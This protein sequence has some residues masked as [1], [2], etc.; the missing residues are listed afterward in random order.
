MTTP[1]P[2]QDED[3][4]NFHAPATW[5]S[6]PAGAG[7][8]PAWRSTSGWPRARLRA[9]S[10]ISWRTWAAWRTT[11]WPR[12]CRWCGPTAGSRSGTAACWRRCPTRPTP[13]RLFAWEPLPLAAFNKMN[14]RTPLGRVAATL[15]EELGWPPERG[16]AYARR[17]VPAPGAAPRLRLSDRER[18][19]SVAGFRPRR[20]R[21]A[22][23][24][25]RRDDPDG[26]LFYRAGLPGRGIA[27][28]GG[29]A[30]RAACGAARLGRRPARAGGWPCGRPAPVCRG[31]SAGVGAGSVGD[32]A[33][34]GGERSPARAGG[35]GARPE[36]RGVPARLFDPVPAQRVQPALRSYCFAEAAPG[37]GPRLDP[38]AIRAGARLV[39]ENCRARGLPMTL[40][41]HGG[42]EPALHLEPLAEALALVETDRGRA[43][44]APVPHHLHQRRAARGDR[45]VDHAALR[46]GGTLVR[47]AAGRAGEPAAGMGRRRQHGPGRA[48][49]CRI[50]RRH[51]ARPA[52][53]ASPSRH[54]RWTGRRRSPSISVRR[55]RP[56]EIHVEPVYAAGRASPLAA[57]DADRFVA[58]FLAARQVAARYGVSWSNSGSRLGEIHGP[59]CN[60]FRDVLNLVP[61]RR[62]A[63]RPAASWSPTRTQPS[64][65]GS[66]SAGRT[67]T[68][69]TIDQPGVAALRRSLAA[70]PAAC[71][72]C[73][74]RY[75]CARACPD[76]C[77]AG[78]PTADGRVPVPGA[79]AVGR[80]G[81]RRAGRPPVAGAGGRGRL[82]RAGAEIGKVFSPCYHPD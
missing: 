9:A 15:A 58:G 1:I 61:A 28:R 18:F 27:R 82:R 35:G 45:R 38:A 24:I 3:F 75:H 79:P 53:A 69:S 52:R 26:S 34:A 72:A 81:D 64:G 11:S 56:S 73:F 67:A 20:G 46:P 39:A 22:A 6:A 76:T 33:R 8:S 19:V 21:R 49:R 77:R 2:A 47:R 29:R 4:E 31:C 68:A 14:G 60:V 17:A 25:F 42:G 70:P 48:D 54:R 55:C 16:F 37:R 50:V 66:P 65:G 23:A 41:C 51:G 43:G 32:P 7:S 44:R 12:L 62:T 59:Y 57:D 30:G 10:A 40:V 13:V 5:S 80:G 78:R 71:D 63:Q 36:R 74:N